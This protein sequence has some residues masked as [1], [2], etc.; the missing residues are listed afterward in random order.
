MPINL[1]DLI[2]AKML[3]TGS[4]SS[5][6][7]SGGGD[8]PEAP[9]DGKTR[10]Y[11][12]LHEGRTSPMVGVCPNGTV[13]VDWGDGTE[14]DVL[15]GTST[16]TVKRTPNHNYASPGDYVITLT[17][18]GQIGLLGA[19]AARQTSYL[20]AY[21]GAYQ[22]SRNDYYKAALARLVLGNGVE[23]SGQQALANFINLKSVNIPDNTTRIYSGT[24]S[25]CLTLQSLSFP[26]SVAT[27]EA[28]AFSQCYGILVYDFTNH[29][30]V[31]ALS[32]TSALQYLPADCEIRVPAALYDEWV[33]ATNWAT[34]A[35]NI[36]AY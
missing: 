12:T 31:P 11:I 36:V 18:D 4:G 3:G 30:A 1:Q 9:D 34:Y 14:P 13:T 17:V 23:L 27:I 10:L 32:A 7:G 26:K 20:L 8:W 19:P 33:A 15:T 5:G 21:N 28:Y 24:F 22:D 6:G 35:S 29:T 2:K 16:S 25:N